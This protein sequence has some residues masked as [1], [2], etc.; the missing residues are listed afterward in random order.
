MAVNIVPAKEIG[1]IGVTFHL[2][3]PVEVN[4]MALE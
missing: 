4:K 1:S 3:C 2:G